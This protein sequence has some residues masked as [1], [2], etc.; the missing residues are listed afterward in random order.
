MALQC[1]VDIETFSKCDLKKVG[2]YRYAED[3]STKVLLV[4]YAFDNDP[5]KV[6]DLTADPVMPRDLDEALSGIC[7]F[8]AH[9][10]MFDRNVLKLVVDERF[11]PPERWRDT[12][13]LAYASALPGSLGALSELLGLPPDKAKDK[14]GKRLVQKFSKPQ[15]RGV[16][17]TRETDPED[18]RKF[19]DYCRK[20]VEAMRDVARRIP[21]WAG[22]RELWADWHLDQRINDRG[23]NIDIG[24]VRHAIA[25]SDELKVLANEKMSELTDGAVATIGQRDAILKHIKDTYGV[26]IEDAR[27]STLLKVLERDDIPEEV[28]SIIETRLGS[29]V[30]SIQKYAAMER[31]VCR[32]GTVKGT[33]QFMGASRTGRFAG[34]GLQ[35][36]NVARGILKTPEAVAEAIDAINTGMLPFVYDEPNKIL[37]SCLRG[38]LIPPP[39]RKF[40]VA[41][42][43]NIEGRVLAWLAGEKWK[44][45]AFK[46]YDQGKGP[47]L[48][49][50]TYARSFGIKP[51]EVTKS[52]RQIGKVMELALGYQGGVGAFTTFATLYG[53]DLDALADHVREAVSNAEWSDALSSWEWA[54]EKDMTKGLSMN[55]YVAC[56]V[57]KR[58]WRNAHPNVV[59]FWKMMERGV[60]SVLAYDEPYETPSNVRFAS[61][62]K[63]WLTI[64][65]PSGRL[66]TY[67]GARWP[68]DGERCDMVFQGVEQKTGK[69]MELKTHGG[70]LCICAGTMVLCRRGWTPIENVT[71]EDEVWDGEDWVQQQG[72]VCNGEREVIRVHGVWMTPDHPVLTTEGWVEGGKAQR[73][74]RAPCRI[75]DGYS[76]D[77]VANDQRDYEVG[78]SVYMRK[79]I[80]QAR[81]TEPVYDIIGCGPRHRFVVLGEEGPLIVHNCENVVQAV[82]RDVLVVG[83]QEAEKAGFQVHAHVHD[84]IIAS[85]PIDSPF[86]EVDL[87]RCMTTERP[88]M[89]GLPLSAAGFT[90]MRYRKE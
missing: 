33:L 3:E 13:I 5:A 38:M 75:P 66:L 52:Q 57:L 25:L 24:T 10:S 78:V 21:T 54:V 23:V 80:R 50:A 1:W 26:D 30:I 68:R 7:T 9:N 58:A 17:K 35:L 18:W 76:P 46:L 34:R 39:G 51:E 84:E 61:P 32:D 65:L 53:V 87:A 70:R 62:R 27:K 86:T 29:A 59:A 11:A 83:L 2:A 42:L 73:H 45:E 36:Q 41:D 20:D 67:P 72:A 4:G 44:I 82:A 71:T 74:N 6:W 43:S 31:M 90:A 47:D 37:S 15:A 12:M 40:V 14:D 28:K 77:G 56:E 19:V 81:R 8:I 69:W 89:R 64:R 63:G 79:Q 85:A 88:W 16:I 49:K 22:G 48:Y 60:T 55:A